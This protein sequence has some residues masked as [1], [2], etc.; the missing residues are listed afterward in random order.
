MVAYPKVVQAFKQSLHI[1]VLTQ[2]PQ[3]LLREPSAASSIID[4]GACSQTMSSATHLFYSSTA[5]G[6]IYNL[7]VSVELMRVFAG[8][9]IEAR[10]EIYIFDIICG[11]RTSTNWR[12]S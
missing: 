3:Q 2:P 12:T 7:D 6:P 8:N 10:D 9:V 11:A 4:V 1:E 5:L